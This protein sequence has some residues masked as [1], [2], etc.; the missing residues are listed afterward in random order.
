MKREAESNTV[1]LTGLAIPHVVVPGEGR[2]EL[3]IARARG[4]ILFPE[5]DPVTSAF[6]LVSSP[7]ER[8]FH[9]RVLAS[10]AGAVQRDGFEAAWRAAEDG[11]TLRALL[12]D[13]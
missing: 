8:T 2:F 7:D 13:R 5:Q 10:I 1:I 11:E 9:L 12:L 3:L 4:G 6:V